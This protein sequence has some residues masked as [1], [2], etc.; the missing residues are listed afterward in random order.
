MYTAALATSAA[1][2]PQAQALINLLAGP[3]AKDMRCRAGFLGA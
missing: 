1:N 3:D 2:A